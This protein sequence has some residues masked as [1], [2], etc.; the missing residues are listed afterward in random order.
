MAAIVNLPVHMRIGE[1]AEFEVGTVIWEPT[2]TE[3]DTTAGKAQL[4]ALLRAAADELEA[5]EG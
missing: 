5:G 3:P 2:D 4:A 1:G